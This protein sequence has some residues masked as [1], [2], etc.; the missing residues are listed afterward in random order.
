[1]FP[2]SDTKS[3]VKNTPSVRASNFVLRMLF[4]LLPTILIFINFLIFFFVL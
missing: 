2:G 3:L 4:L 1:M